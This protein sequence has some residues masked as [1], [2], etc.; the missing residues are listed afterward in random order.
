MNTKYRLFGG[1]A[2]RFLFGLKVSILTAAF[3][4]CLAGAAG[5][6][7][8]LNGWWRVLED[9]GHFIKIQQ[10]GTDVTILGTDQPLLYGTFIND[11]LWVFLTDPIPDTVILVYANDTLSGLNEVGDP[12]NLVRHIVDLTGWWKTLETSDYTRME[13][14]GTNVFLWEED[15]SPLTNATFVNDTLSIPLPE[16]WSVTLTYIYFAD[17]LR[18]VNPD[19]DPETLVRALHGLWTPVRCGTIVVDGDTSDWPDTFLVDDDPD[20]DATNGNPS[21]DLDKFWLCHDSTYLYMRIDCVGDAAFPHSWDYQDRYGVLMGQDFSQQPEYSIRFWNTY[22]INFRNNITGEETNLEA[23]GVSGHTIEGR[24]PLYLFGNLQQYEIKVGSDYYDW[25]VG[26]ES[27]DKIELRA[28]LSSCLGQRSLLMPAPQYAIYAYRIDP[29]IDT[30]IIGDLENHGV[31]DIDAGTVRINGSIQPSAVMI[32]P[33]YPEFTGE[34]MQILF[35]AAP[36][37][38]G[39]EP[40]WDS[41]VRQYVVTGDYVNGGSLSIPGEVLFIGHRSGDANSDGQ[42]DIADVMFLIGYIFRDGDA[43][44]PVDVGDVNGDGRVNLGDPIY[45]AKYIFGIGPPPC[46]R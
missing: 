29:L 17:T 40:V 19:G 44:R 7:T 35:P 23:P 28:R 9:N 18:G 31:A 15:G 42:V 6:L 34:V 45:L 12:I 38:K 22:S 3:M 2:G 37:I 46:H 41:T 36:F 21:A 43:P 16:P 26:W 10:Q 24:I 33:D 13:Q 14:Q 27:Y 39:Y 1:P 25:D 32:L 30:V 4:F 8:D 11:T 5:F 20:N